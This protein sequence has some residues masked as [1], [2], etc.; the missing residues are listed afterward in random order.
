M[1]KVNVGGNTFQDVTFPLVFENR[2][3]MLEPSSDKDIWTIFF[4]Q[5]RET[6]LEVLKNQPQENLFTEIIT[7]P[8]GIITVSDR[9]SGKFL[10]NIRPGN[11]STSIF[12]SLQGQETEIKI[13]DREIRVGS[14]IFQANH[15]IGSYIGIVVDKNGG[16]GMGGALPP[17]IQKLLIT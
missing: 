13:T 8:T 4:L 17:E 5:G 6:I 14:N 15:V 10:Y 16:I 11:K 7:N 1:T 9:E 2:Y 12:G 3:F